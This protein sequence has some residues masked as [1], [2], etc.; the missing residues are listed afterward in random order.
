MLR[1]VQRG[2]GHAEET[3]GRGGRKE[4]RSAASPNVP[5]D[6]F[7]HYQNLIQ[8]HVA[9]EL[10]HRNHPPADPRPDARAAGA[11]RTWSAS[12]WPS[13]SKSSIPSCAAIARRA[14]ATGPHVLALIGPTGV[15]KTTTLAKLAANL[16]LKDGHRVGLITLDTYR[17]AA[18]DQLRRYAEII[19]SPLKVVSDARRAAVGRVGLHGAHGLRPDRH[20]RPQP[21]RR[22]AKLGELRVLLDS[23]NPD[24]VH[25]VLSSTSSQRPSSWPASGSATVRVDKIIF[26]KLDEASP[27][28]RGAERVPQGEQGPVVR[29][30]RAGRAQRHRGRPGPAAGAR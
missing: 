10:A 16:K 28:R 25:L 5:D 19:G 15:G 3:G 6:L 30:H 9:E 7:D 1:N 26:T 14:T 20:R 11:S 24:D 12:G 8:N 4:T 29:D 17:I 13:T 2:N 27:R 18:V 23:I 22:D 21:Q